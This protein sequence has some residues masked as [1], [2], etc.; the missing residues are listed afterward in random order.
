MSSYQLEDI[1][2]RNHKVDCKRIHLG[3][4]CFNKVLIILIRG[5]ILKSINKLSSN[6]GKQF[7]KPMI[8]LL[9]IFHSC[10]F[11][12]YPRSS[13]IKCGAVTVRLTSYCKMDDK[14]RQ[15]SCSKQILTFESKKTHTKISKSL[16]DGPG[17][18]DSPISEWSCSQGISNKYIE[19]MRCLA[20]NCDVGNAI[21]FEIW[22]LRGDLLIPYNAD[23][24]RKTKKLGIVSPNEFKK[25]QLTE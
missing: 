21:E 5:V 19:V 12:D 14:K 8:F 20:G 6:T 9:A 7:L 17:F 25:L 13:E 23:F 4:L 16:Q 11:A 24:S 22:S 2:K 10:C 3:E 1:F 15:L 18:L